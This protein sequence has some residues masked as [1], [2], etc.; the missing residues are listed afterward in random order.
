[1]SD[2]RA[3]LKNRFIELA[4]KSYNSGIFTFT[5][6]LGLAEQDVFREAEAAIRPLP[7][8]LFGGTEGT[9][10]VMVRFGD[11]EEFGYELPFPNSVVKVEPLSQRFADRL[12]HRDFL[13]AILNLGIERSRLGD[14]V[15]RDNVGYV[16]AREDIA[17]YIADSLSRIKHTDVRATVT[18]E[19][20]EE[21][22]LYKTEMRRIQL[23]GERVDAVIAKVFSLS[24]DDAQALFKRGL[25]FVSGRCVESV[26][27]TPRE[28]DVISVR[29]YG[30]MIYRGPSSTSRKGKLN[31]DVELFV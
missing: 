21:G 30:R 25:V 31:V 6:F 23:S 11:A 28:G 15:I 24:R 14:I 19:L 4:R 16:F 3:L 18:E 22:E 26:S 2:E 9:E 7:Y 13:G 17:V 10:R 12:G 5:D 29:G 8:T 27:H 20:P 1:M